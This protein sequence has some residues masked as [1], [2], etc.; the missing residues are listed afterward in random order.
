MDGTRRRID[1]CNIDMYKVK[2]IDGNI[3][4]IHV[5]KI[6][7]PTSRIQAVGVIFENEQELGK[8]HPMPRKIDEMNFFNLNEVN[9]NHLEEFQRKEI[10]T[11]SMKHRNLFLNKVQIAKV[12]EHQ[13]KLIET[14]RK[15]QFIYKIPEALKT[16]VDRQ[17]EELLSLGLLEKCDSEIS[18]PVIYIMKKDRIL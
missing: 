3:K 2:L 16:Q 18:Y 7:K 10:E 6:G 15:K 14:E 1:R 9:L 5:N 12:G 8:A 17:V 4:S 11:L 13:I